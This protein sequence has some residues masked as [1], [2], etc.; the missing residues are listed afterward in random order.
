LNQLEQ[1]ELSIKSSTNDEGSDEENEGEIDEEIKQDVSDNQTQSPSH[2]SQT[3]PSFVC[4]K[5]IFNKR[6]TTESS[7]R[8][9]HQF[10]FH[11]VE[12]ER[13]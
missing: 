7:L 12:R 11:S 4:L 6:K 8:F 5:T 13:N 1:I 2:H 10:L 3:L 9:S